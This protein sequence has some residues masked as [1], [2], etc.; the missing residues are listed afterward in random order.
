MDYEGNSL[1]QFT[2]RFLIPYKFS[3]GDSIVCSW[4]VMLSLISKFHVSRLHC[5]DAKLLLLL[6]LLLLLYNYILNVFTPQSFQD[7]INKNKPYPNSAMTFWPQIFDSSVNY[8]HSS[9]VNLVVSQCMS[10]ILAFI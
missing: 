2:I 7:H 8:W 4:P 3:P 5:S 1:R 9:P 6:L 10:R